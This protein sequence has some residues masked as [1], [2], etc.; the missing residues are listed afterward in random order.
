MKIPG[1]DDLL[2][3]AR[4][5]DLSS[6]AAVYDR[7]SLGLYTYATRL[8]GDASL[9]EDCVAETFSRFLKGLRTGGGPDRYLQAYLYRTAHNWITDFYRRQPP[10][11]LELNEDWRAAAALQPE[12]QVD[13][14]LERERVRCALRSLTPD[15]RQVV[16]LRFYEGWENEEVAAAVQKP[17][18]AVKA[19][20]HRALAALRK[21]LLPAELEGLDV[22]KY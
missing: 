5:L 12:A 1:E 7:Y 8:L 11:P 15:Q 13:R 14:H 20:Q 17:V 18:G 21:Y 9:A 2:T 16:I 10:E 3:G 4:A 6:L 22:Q 19:L